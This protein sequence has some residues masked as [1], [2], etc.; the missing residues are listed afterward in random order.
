MAYEPTTTDLE[1]KAVRAALSTLRS[2]LPR[3]YRACFGATNRASSW[4]TASRYSGLATRLE[5]ALKKGP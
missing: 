4:R 3:K 5:K 2:K 1:F